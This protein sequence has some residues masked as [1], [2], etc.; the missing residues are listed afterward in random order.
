MK[1]PWL[2]T[3]TIFVHLTLCHGHYPLKDEYSRGYLVDQFR[4]HFPDR[5]QHIFHS[6]E[7]SYPAVANSEDGSSN[8]F[9][10]YNEYYPRRNNAWRQNVPS[11][12][13]L[14][15]VDI[16]SDV[17]SVPKDNIEDQEIDRLEKIA[18]QNVQPVNSAGDQFKVTTRAQARQMG[19]PSSEG[20]A[21]HL[22]SSITST[23]SDVYFI[24]LVAG[25]SAAAVFGVMAAGFCW[26][27]F[28]KNAKA[29]A[30]A[31]YPAYGV[32]GPNKEH[33]MP[34][35]GGDRKLAQSAQMYHYQHQKQQMIA[36]EKTNGE[37]Q[38]STSDL[39]SEEENEEG[40]YTV[41]ECPGL[42]PTC[43]MEV[44]NPLFQDEPTPASPPVSAK[45]SNGE[46]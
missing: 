22:Q 30:E 29:A 21:H 18:E 3:A 43:E 9:R 38:V 13:K 42:A 27:K 44:K 35:G 5:R 7:G 23:T 16:E 8:D 6:R 1:E 19:G 4:R 17:N 12:T 39:D 14:P 15:V 31:E 11:E 2:F 24:A 34:S 20:T 25:C 40:D 45:P 10:G 32:T 36:M 37:R 33:T 46:K 41:Y 26:Y 28:Q